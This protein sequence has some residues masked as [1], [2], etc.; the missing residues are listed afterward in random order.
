[1]RAWEVSMI[2]QLDGPRSPPIRDLTRGRIGRLSDQI[3]QDPSQGGTYVWRAITIRRR[4]YPGEG[5]GN[6]DYRRPHQGQRP[7]DRRACPNGDGRPPDRGGYPGG[8]PPDGGGLLDP[9]ED[10]DH[11]VLKDLLGL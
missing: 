11:Q 4:K 3:E 1:M 5:N 6:D 9:L 2:P 8:G 10:K 7:P